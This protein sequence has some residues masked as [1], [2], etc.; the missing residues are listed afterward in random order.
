MSFPTPSHKSS[1]FNFHLIE[2][3]R[4]DRLA[5]GRYYSQYS[6]DIH[7]V[8]CQRRGWKSRDNKKGEKLQKIVILTKGIINWR[9]H[10][11]FSS[12]NAVKIV[13]DMSKAIDAN[14]HILQSTFTTTPIQNIWIP[15]KQ[16]LYT[17]LFHIMRDYV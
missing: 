15:S 11:F 5:L 2:Y 10:L 3:V 8:T 16:L 13:T 14:N 4:N 6:A 7:F 1:L 17:V 12:T 9:I